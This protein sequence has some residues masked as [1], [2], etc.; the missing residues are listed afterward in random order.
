MKKDKK[1]CGLIL[2]DLFFQCDICLTWQ[3]GNCNDIDSE[4]NVPEKYICNKCSNPELQRSSMKYNHLHDWI[5]D[6]AQPRSVHIS[7]YS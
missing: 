7:I 4:E 2:T 3:H 6:G 5:T 1:E